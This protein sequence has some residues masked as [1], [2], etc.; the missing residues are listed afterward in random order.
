M[1]KSEND[2]DVK[3][4]L[5]ESAVEINDDSGSSMDDFI[6]DGTITEY[7]W[8]I[9]SL[10]GC[11]DACKKEERSRVTSTPVEKKVLHKT[12]VCLSILYLFNITRVLFVENHT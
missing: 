1:D 7:S 3:S 6:N 4:L 10:S 8:S 9:S 11:E 5:D 2:F 12:F